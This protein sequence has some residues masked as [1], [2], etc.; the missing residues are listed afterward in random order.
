MDKRKNCCG[1]C[2][3]GVNRDNSSEKYKFV[4]RDANEQL[5]EC[6]FCDFWLNDNGIDS[7]R[8]CN[9]DADPCED[10]ERRITVSPLEWAD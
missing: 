5:H 6:V 2:I 9:A 10:Y 8:I 3:Y 4:I 1:T 7:Y